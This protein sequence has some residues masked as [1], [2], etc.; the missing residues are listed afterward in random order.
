MRRLLS[1]ASGAVPTVDGA[2]SPRPLSL[3]ERLWARGAAPRRSLPRWRTAFG[4]VARSTRFGHI[5][6]GKESI[7]AAAVSG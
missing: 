2:F 5:I 7:S 6:D 4:E 1:A 3:V